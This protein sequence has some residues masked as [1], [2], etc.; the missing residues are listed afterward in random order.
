MKNWVLCRWSRLPTKMCWNV[1]VRNL[2][3]MKVISPIG[4]NH[5]N[6]VID[7]GVYEVAICIMAVHA[8]LPY[9][10]CHHC[11]PSR[12][13]VRKKW[14][15]TSIVAT[16][17]AIIF[18]SVE[19]KQ[20]QCRTVPNLSKHGCRE[21]PIE[22]LYIQDNQGWGFFWAGEQCAGTAARNGTR[23]LRGTNVPFKESSET[24]ERVGRLNSS[25]YWESKPRVREGEK[26]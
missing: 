7:W 4:Q 2:R 17:N 6:R 22:A 5:V 26:A 23:K 14:V 1:W 8:C 13:T 16:D 10:A 15:W 20:I 18:S 3:Q 25:Y 21:H 9:D 12:L 24:S 19:N 11:N